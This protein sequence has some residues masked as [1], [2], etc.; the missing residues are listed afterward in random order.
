M[1]IIYSPNMV[2]PID[3]GGVIDSFQMKCLGEIT[4]LYYF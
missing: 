4:Y 3:G 1:N 2:N